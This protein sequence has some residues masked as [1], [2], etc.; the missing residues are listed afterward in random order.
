MFYK[1][2]KKLALSLTGFFWA[3]CGSDVTA[4]TGGDANTSSSS[5]DGNLS[6]SSDVTPKS[7]N[8]FSQIVPL[9][10]INLSSIV[11]SSSSSDESSSSLAY[12]MP[13][14]GVYEKVPCYEDA[15]GVKTNGEIAE[16]KLYCD[17]GTI[18]KER[19]VL[20]TFDPP[21]S[22]IDED[23]LE[24]AVVC[25][26]YGIVHITE[27]TYSCDGVTYNKTEFES[28]YYKAG[29]KPA[30]S[31]STLQSSSS[32]DVFEGK[33]PCHV[34]D[35][36]YSCDDGEDYTQVQGEDGKT[37]FV[38]ANK[39]LSEEQFYERYYLIMETTVLYGSPCVFNNTCDDK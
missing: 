19:E 25:P 33:T 23:D 21:C 30:S 8:D 10:G 1:H 9:Y 29:V 17:D 2:W 32:E 18:C 26:D 34:V 31:S 13:A 6:S 38:N 4:P 28:R 24:G 15:K 14:Y 3:S 16:T 36:N 22:P 5:N 35:Q 11:Q 37:Y 12:A 39:Q 27:K 20:K 7:S